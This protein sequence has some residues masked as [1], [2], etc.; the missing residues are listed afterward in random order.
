MERGDLYVVFGPSAAGKTTL[1]DYIPTRSDRPDY[2]YLD[3]DL[4]YH[5]VFLAEDIVEK[6]VMDA[7][8]LLCNRI[9]RSGRPVVLFT[10]AQPELFEKLEN[11]HLVRDIHYLA[12][13]C[14]DDELAIRLKNRSTGRQRNTPEAVAGMQ[15]WSN[16][17]RT[18]DWG[19][20]ALMGDGVF[21]PHDT[22]HQ[23]VDETASTVFEW[24]GGHR[25]Q[26]DVS[27]GSSRSP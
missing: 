20:G 18:G 19:Y 5:L 13:Y 22:T 17:I 4:L 21:T 1:V 14:S 2:V 12:L 23:T 11:R 7:W 9:A 16:A 3:G 8:L 6:T 24:L 26:G 10:G 27:D 15:R 25:A